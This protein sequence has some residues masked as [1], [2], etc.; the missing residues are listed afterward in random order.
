[1]LNV[2]LCFQVLFSSLVV[3]VINCCTLTAVADSVEVVEEKDIVQCP[4]GP[5]ATETIFLGN[6]TLVFC[7]SDNTIVIDGFVSRPS[8][9]QMALPFRPGKARKHVNRVFSS[10]GLLSENNREKI[11]CDESGESK[12]DSEKTSAVIPLH[13]HFDHLLDA[14]Y[15]AHVSGAELIGSD[16]LHSLAR[17]M[18]SADSSC[19]QA[20]YNRRYLTQITNDERISTTYGQYE[21]TLERARHAVLPSPV[22][23]FG[24]RLLAPANSHDKGDKFSYRRLRWSQSMPEGDSWN[25]LVTHGSEAH[26]IVGGIPERNAGFN[27]IVD[28]DR[29][30]DDTQFEHIAVYIA[31]ATYGNIALDAKQESDFWSRFNNFPEVRVVPVHWDN[32]FKPIEVGVKLNFNRFSPLPKLVENLR[33][34]VN[35]QNKKTLK[36]VYRFYRPTFPF[37]SVSDAEIWS[38]AIQE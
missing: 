25:V 7:D 31:A 16:A 13:N 29:L 34:K 20:N 19:D 1:M 28:F 22:L 17:S 14:P 8:I 2:R 24:Q 35:Q 3:L 15:L 27:S 5:G 11:E 30:M 9:K 21:V 6:T 18:L 12:G 10:I 38:S 23:R 33:E 32:I 26:Y 36:P 4:A 37:T